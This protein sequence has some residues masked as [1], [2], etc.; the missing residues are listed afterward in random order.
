[1]RP[2]HNHTWNHASTDEKCTI[3]CTV[4]TQ[5]GETE[6]PSIICDVCD[7]VSLN[8]WSSPTFDEAPRAEALVTLNQNMVAFAQRNFPACPSAAAF[9]IVVPRPRNLGNRDAEPQE[10]HFRPNVAV[11]AAPCAIRDG[12]GQIGVALRKN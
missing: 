6:S 11:V 9:I 5:H 1:M 3:I 8:L 7:P 12:E 4:D 10:K 2:N